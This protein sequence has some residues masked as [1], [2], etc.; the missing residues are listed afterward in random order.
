[1]FVS[2]D[3]PDALVQNLLYENKTL[4]PMS[5]IFRLFLPMILFGMI[6]SMANG[7]DGADAAASVAEAIRKADAGR[8]GS[9]LNQRV[10]MELPGN[11]GIYSS[12]QAEVILR[13]FFRRHPVSGFENRHSG[14]SG[15]GA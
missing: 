5:K 8:L 1:M 2:L 6:P 4:S 11:E 3:H 7:Q 15:E 13:E 12:T 9:M 14:R 10:D